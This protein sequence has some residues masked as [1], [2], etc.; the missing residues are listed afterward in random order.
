MKPRL[1]A[2]LAGV[3]A[4]GLCAC[5]PAGA[6]AESGSTATAASAAPSP[7]SSTTT[8]SSAAQTPQM[9]GDL[10]M[11]DNTF[12]VTVN[13]AT[14]SAVFAET[15]AA[16]ALQELLAQGDL[17]LSLQDYGS[18]EKVGPLGQSLP[19]SDVQ[20]TT[21]VGDI[22]LYQGDQVVMFYGSNAWAYTR[23]G[24]VQ[25]LTGWAQALGSGDVQVTFSLTAPQ[26]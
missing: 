16:G 11:N 24:A 18:F 9:E 12:Y 19:A 4:L 25:D 26:A 5:A 20:T 10:S 3:L 17:T 15:A 6:A 13:G 22:V 14:F 8:V 2:F 7:G 1:Y 21:Q 23:L